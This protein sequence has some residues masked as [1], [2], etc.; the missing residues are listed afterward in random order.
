MFMPWRL[1]LGR[2]SAQDFTANIFS[3]E[4][5]VYFISPNSCLKASGDERE[6]RAKTG[7]MSPTPW[8]TNPGKQELDG[9]RGRDGARQ[10]SAFGKIKHVR[11]SPLV[12]VARSERRK[13][14][15]GI[16]QLTWTALWGMWVSLTTVSLPNKQALSW[17]CKTNR[18]VSLISGPHS[19][20]S[21][22]HPPPPPKK[23]VFLNKKWKHVLNE[24]PPAPDR[25]ERAGCV[26]VLIV[27]AQGWVGYLEQCSVSQQVHPLFWHSCSIIIGCRSMI[28]IVLKQ[29]SN[30]F[31][32]S[33]LTL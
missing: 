29:Y 15:G 28:W 3:K 14:V 7:E 13:R 9:E 17:Q 6:E 8:G 22:V 10:T 26:Q 24:S 31:S 21:K 19:V 5:C 20:S 18:N 25:S 4:L 30:S 33:C 27:C 16:K 2:G 23:R 32:F 11:L 1:K 12:S